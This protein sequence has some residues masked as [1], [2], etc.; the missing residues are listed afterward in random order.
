MIKGLGK[1]MMAYGKE[2]P[3]GLFCCF[4]MTSVI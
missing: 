3:N 4:E 2:F 1:Y